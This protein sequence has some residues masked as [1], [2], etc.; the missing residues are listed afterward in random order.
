VFLRLADTAP[1]SGADTFVDAADGTIGFYDNPVYA[2]AWSVIVSRGW[3]RSGPVAVTGEPGI[4]KS[5][6]MRRV[7]RGLGEG[8][9]AVSLSPES[10]ELT[11][12][13]DLIEGALGPPGAEVRPIQNPE[14]RLTHC[15][16]RLTRER[17]GGDWIVL[18]VDDADDLP[19]ATLAELLRLALPDPDGEPILGLVLAGLPRLER[20]LAK[21]ELRVLVGNHLHICRLRPLRA[22]EVGV[23]IQKRCK[24]AGSWRNQLLSP[25]AA[26]RIGTYSRGIP[27]LINHLCDAATETAERHHQ[28]RITEEIVEEAVQLYSDSL[29]LRIDDGSTT[30]DPVGSESE[31]D[32]PGGPRAATTVGDRCEVSRSGPLPDSEA[33][34]TGMRGADRVTPSFGPTSETESSGRGGGGRELRPLRRHPQPLPRADAPT[35]TEPVKWNPQWTAQRASTKC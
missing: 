35:P 15:R 16:Q 9:H 27:R 12:A 21:P 17:G 23:Y 26:A 2:Y 5:L 7:I 34:K 31:P 6:L 4:G 25:L 30:A 3:R 1:A 29:G 18:F 11:D 22:C 8:V 32:P 19:D 20:Q 28:K 13:L 24:V 10:R 14:L 33:G